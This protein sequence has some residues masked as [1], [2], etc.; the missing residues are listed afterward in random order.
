MPN[1]T[2]NEEAL[3]I[4]EQM[5]R[6]G[7]SDEAIQNVIQSWNKPEEQGVVTRTVEATKGALKQLGQKVAV[8]E[9]EKQRTKEAEK[10]APFV[11][12]GKVISDITRYF[13][14]PDRGGAR[15]DILME[16]GIPTIAQ[17]AT[18]ELGPWT[19]AA[20]GFTAG[21]LG[22]AAAQTRRV[23]AGEQKK[24]NAGEIV[25]SAFLSAPPGGSVAKGVA[26]EIRPVFSAVK[27]AAKQAGY[28]SAAGLIGEEARNLIDEGEWATPQEVGVSTALP[29]VFSSLFM[30]FSVIGARA[31]QRAQEIGPRLETL[32]KT[33]GS[34]TPGQI[35][36][37][38]FGN[39]ERH[40]MES[41]PRMSVNVDY[42]RSKQTLASNIESLTTGIKPATEVLSEISP[43]LNQR[44]RA[45]EFKLKLSEKA[46]QLQSKLDDAT[47]AL[48]VA[49]KEDDPEKIAQLQ[50]IQDQLNS[51][52]F[53]QKH[54]DALEEA[55]Q[56][57]LGEM[58][59]SSLRMSPA[60]QTDAWRTRVVNPLIEAKTTYFSKQYGVF[61]NEFKA[62]HPDEII[63]VA[64]QYADTLETML[65]RDLASNVKTV[66]RAMQGGDVSLRTLRDL[67]STLLDGVK[68]GNLRD[69]ASEHRIK[70]IAAAVTETIN[71]QAKEVY[72][73][74]AGE[75]LL[76][77]N[78][79]T[80]EWHNIIDSTGP[81][82]LVSS[83][84]G[85]DEARKLIEGGKD[86]LVQ[87][88]IDAESFKNI[89]RLETWLEAVSPESVQSFRTARNGIIRGALMDMSAVSRVG[90]GGKRVDGTK[91]MQYLK[92]IEDGKAGS[93]AEL[94][95]PGGEAVAEMSA[96]F[97]KYPDAPTMTSE[98][99]S[100]LLLSP[101]WKK[102]AGEA[103]QIVEGLMVTSQSRMLLDRAAQLN[104]AGAVDVARKQYE[105]AI[106][107]VKEIGG[108]IRAADEY[109]QRISN[110]PLAIAFNNDVLSDSNMAKFL[111]PFIGTNQIDREASEA[112]VKALKD[113]HKDELLDQI[114]LHMLAG[115]LNDS[116]E[117]APRFSQQAQQLNVRKVAGLAESRVQGKMTQTWNAIEPW[118]TP[119]QRT[120]IQD[121]ANEAYD[122]MLADNL[123][124]RGIDL[125]SYG[126]PVV[127]TPRRALDTTVSFLDK[128]RYEWA[129]WNMFKESGLLG[130]Y[131][132]RLELESKVLTPASAFATGLS[133][134]KA[135]QRAQQ[136]RSDRKEDKTNVRLKA[137]YEV[138][139]KAAPDGRLNIDLTSE[140]PA[141]A[142][143]AAPL[144]HPPAP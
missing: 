82:F 29:A 39:V 34:A 58:T 144:F 110:D 84:L 71:N 135:A 75:L 143:A 11:G 62:F 5:M 13:F 3:P 93:L 106:Q 70:E 85:G 53:V 120:K 79:Q 49:Y 131:A 57:S 113:A 38:E 7:E 45:A 21:G 88:G 65:P 60:E 68:I 77:L 23:M 102:N 89:R 33:G 61:N 32:R 98:Q 78:K 72:G 91:L 118:F 121:L 97:Q 59:G 94:G 2:S 136:R 10:Y 92:S 67:R 19:Q 100:Q 90:I 103:V 138:D 137:P 127:G 51:Q 8:S 140:E 48:Q 35:A 105:K 133:L 55:R 14:D 30:P 142:E 101:L 20:V 12:S 63:R 37:E 107:S 95:F 119:E 27:G 141:P 4:V 96:L 111:Q 17:A 117:D 52:L 6:D 112:M 116:F 41:Q 69:T 125:G 83:K 81:D 122:K 99:W 25:S 42:D 26:K 22:S 50:S 9:E 115:M 16:E 18:T 123:S 104:A 109:Y 44:T 114:R 74:T 24:V 108:D 134:D 43:I 36:A 54:A 139:E 128:K 76:K 40:I 130:D 31:K 87:S 132:Q 73:D 64:N 15:A 28:A 129:A 46:T 47:T 66:L 126:V 56:L 86:S 80:A 124:G 1:P